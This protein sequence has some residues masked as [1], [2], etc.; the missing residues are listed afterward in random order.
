MLMMRFAMMTMIPIMISI[1]SFIV[2]I[3]NIPWHYDLPIKSKVSCLNQEIE[4]LLAILFCVIECAN[5]LCEVA[6]FLVMSPSARACTRSSVD[7][8]W[9]NKLAKASAYLCMIH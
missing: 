6:C 5:D 4:D 2:I 9:V 3:L 8:K 1:L 7:C